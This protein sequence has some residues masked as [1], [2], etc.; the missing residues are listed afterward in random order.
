M[1]EQ[2]NPTFR[3]GDLVKKRSGSHWRGK[4]VGEYST[5]LTQEGY[6]VESDYHPGSVQIYPVGAL[7]L[8]L[9]AEAMK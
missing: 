8:V 6:A 1:S 4:V 9:P 2:T 3:R 7:R 5:E